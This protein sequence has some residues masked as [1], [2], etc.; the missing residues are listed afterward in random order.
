MYLPLVQLWLKPHKVERRRQKGREE[1]RMGD[2]AP[3]KVLSQ[4]DRFL[5]LLLTPIRG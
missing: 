2:R 4:P 5:L 1:Q 3:L